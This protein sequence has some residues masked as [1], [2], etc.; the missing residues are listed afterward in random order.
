MR[1]DER[2]H[3]G[4]NITLRQSCPPGVGIGVGRI[5]PDPGLARLEP[6]WR[7]LPGIR[8]MRRHGVTLVEGSSTGCRNCMSR[9]R[10]YPVDEELRVSESSAS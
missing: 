6:S 2:F 4:R 3:C 7:L 5:G 1:V 8:R 9:M 10:D